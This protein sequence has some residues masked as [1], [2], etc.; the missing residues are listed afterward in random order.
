M[1]QCPA[2]ANPPWDVVVIGTGMGGSA[3]G[4]ICAL[5]GLKTLIVD[6]NPAPGGACSCY[7]KQGF[8]LDTGTHLFIRCNRGPFGD[9]T[10]RL[11]MGLPI[12]FRRTR[13]LTHVKGMNVDARIPAGRAGMVMALPLLIWQLKIH[14]RYH[15]PILRLFY[16]IARMTPR[17]IEAL[18][19][20]SIETFL[21]RYTENPEVRA[22]MGIL[23]GLFFVLPPW[24]ASAG[25]SIW[26]LQKMFVENC[27][28]YPK[29]GAITIPKT[30]LAGA[31]RHGAEVR[32][33]CGVKKIEIQHNRVKAVILDNGERVTTRSVISTTALRDT[34]FRLAGAGLFPSGYVAGVENIKQAWTAVQAKIA[35]KKRL[36][37]AGSMVGCVPL[38]FKI[39]DR[40][41]REAMARVENGVQSDTIPIYAPVPTNYD[42]DLAPEG[43]HIITAAAVAPTLD[44]PLADNEQVW[45]DGLMNALHQMVPGLKENTLFADTWTVTDLAGWIGKDS[46]SVIT[47]AQT[48]DQVGPGRPDHRTPVEGLYIAGDCAGPARGVGTELACRSGMDCGDLVSADLRRTDGEPEHSREP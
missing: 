9:L 21:L 13:Y 43:C 2:E 45:I 41:V 35:V 24:E 48:V 42:P 26:N 3:A 34:V 27:L 19:K 30:F 1:I 8:R 28:G 46:G 11:G 16:D 47:T 22:M 40:V 32:L 25:E 17:H 20:V 39:E 29:G 31:E 6:K 15:G 4:A 44:V 36:I 5:N 37:H 14:P 10:K 12:E 7:E 18:D 33:K 23:L 38:R